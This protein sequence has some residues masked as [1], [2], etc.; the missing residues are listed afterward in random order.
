MIDGAHVILFAPQAEAVREFLGE[1]LGMGSVDA[2]GG[3][4]IY[5]LP[6]AELAV[7][8]T[9]GEPRHEL[10]LM[11]SDLDATMQRLEERGAS[12]AKPSDEPFGRLTSIEVPGL[13]PLCLY[14]P[15]HPRPEPVSS[16]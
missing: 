4:P 16:V 1:T 13:G 9:D 12:V 7:H 10:Y 5:G 15:R 8:P 14:E 11:C 6:P 2:G 3:W